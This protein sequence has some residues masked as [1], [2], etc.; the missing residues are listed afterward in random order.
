[1][2]TKT[3]QNRRR[4]R[5]GDVF[6]IP[7]KA[8]VAYAQ[9]IYAHREPPR[10]GAL[11][12][13][14]EPIFESPLEDLLVVV[15]C[16][17]RFLTFFPLGAAVNRGIFQIVGNAPIPSKYAAL[18]MFRAASRFDGG[19]QGKVLTWSFWDGQSRYTR[20][21]SELT[22]SEKRM[23]IKQCVTDVALID[24]IEKNWR[25]ELCIERDW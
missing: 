20:E 13:V 19:F 3:S 17:E 12:R 4:V 2:T 15:G 24:M 9:Y 7:T 22:E 14:F 8:G 10:Y 1:M 5:L 21:T 11:I 16:P 18:P 23:S 25:P 6:A